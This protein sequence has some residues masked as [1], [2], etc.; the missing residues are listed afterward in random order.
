L[1]EPTFLSFDEIIDIHEEQITLY[2]GHPGI[3]NIDLLKSAIAV[4][5]SSFG[6][7]YLCADFY[8]MAAAYLFHIVK[9]HPFVDGNKRTAALTSYVFLK[10]NGLHLIA[11]ED[12]YE[13]IVLGVAEGKIDKTAIAGFF[14][15]NAS[16]LSE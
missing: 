4:P 13:K 6:G 10:L 11:S 3:L 2:G 7:E 12:E 1:R 5:A 16:P 14:L 8:E 9:D 15:D